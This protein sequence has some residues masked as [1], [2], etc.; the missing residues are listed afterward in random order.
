MIQLEIEIEIE[1]KIE[2]NTPVFTTTKFLRN[3]VLLNCR[4]S[5]YLIVVCQIQ[6]L[7]TMI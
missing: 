6:K 5:D 2:T 3:F 4:V 1:I 7:F